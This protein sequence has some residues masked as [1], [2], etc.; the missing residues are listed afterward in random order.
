MREE[1]ERTGK[2]K[3]V[4]EDPFADPFADSNGAGEYEV[5]TPGIQDKRME[6]KEI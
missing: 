2:H 4:E 6:W 3:A 1:D 5:L